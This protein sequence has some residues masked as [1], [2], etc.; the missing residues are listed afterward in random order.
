MRGRSA[1][2]VPL[3]FNMMRDTFAGS[4]W[5][6]AG[7]GGSQVK[8]PTSTSAQEIGLQN[9]GRRLQTRQTGET[10]CPKRKPRIAWMRIGLNCL[11]CREISSWSLASAAKRS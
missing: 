4:A 6:E 11:A 1:V 7:E 10:V 2:V 5:A 8:K 9:I 3:G